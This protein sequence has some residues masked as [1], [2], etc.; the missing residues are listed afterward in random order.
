MRGM[1]V[2]EFVSLEG[3]MEDPGR[4]EKIEH[5]GLTMSYWNEEYG[6]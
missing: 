3:I 1:V 6:S 5:D 4:A 2:S